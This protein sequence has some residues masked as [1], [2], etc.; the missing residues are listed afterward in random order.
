[1][2]PE[3]DE[4]NEVEVARQHV[5]VADEECPCPLCRLAGKIQERYW[6]VQENRRKIFAHN[7]DWRSIG[8]R[9]WPIVD[10]CP[11]DMKLE[12]FKCA[13]CGQLYVPALDDI[14]FH[15]NHKGCIVPLV[16]NQEDD[17]T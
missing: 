5:G 1:M 16:D 6:E 9:D 12:T 7:H 15:P 8:K 3:I 2:K 11:G 17:L 10:G 14:P 13:T 4:I